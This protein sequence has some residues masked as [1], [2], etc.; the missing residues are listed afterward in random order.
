[1]S[2]A[3]Y[4]QCGYVCASAPTRSFL[5]TVSGAPPES[6]DHTLRTT[7]TPPEVIP[8]MRYMYQLMGGSP[9]HLLR[10]AVSANGCDPFRAYS[11]AALLSVLD[12]AMRNHRLAPAVRKVVH[13]MCNLH[14]GTYLHH[15]RLAYDDVES[16]F[17]REVSYRPQRYYDFSLWRKCVPAAAAMERAARHLLQDMHSSAN[18]KDKIR[19]HF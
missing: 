3:D 5:R 17:V 16:L 9:R 6:D 1:M 10:F 2:E 13:E 18:L 19:T 12:E 14:I 11:E 8:V 7:I 4:L 15:R